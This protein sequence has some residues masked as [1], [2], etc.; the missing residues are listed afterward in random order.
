MTSV[1]LK[2]WNQ[3]NLPVCPVGGRRSLPASSSAWPHYAVRLPAASSQYS[4]A[5]DE[6]R[7]RKS[8]ISIA[9]NSICRCSRDEL[10]VRRVWHLPRA[11]PPSSVTAENVQTFINQSNSTVPSTRSDRDDFST[12]NSTFFKQLDQ[13]LGD[14]ASISS[15]RSEIDDIVPDRPDDPFPASN[16][17]DPIDDLDGII[18]TDDIPM[19]FHDALDNLPVNDAPLEIYNPNF[20]IPRAHM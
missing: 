15:L 12:F 20:R 1:G 3:P 7:T 10:R 2:R 5:V 8:S 13:Q 6:Q 16:R 19:L 11:T 18:D 17:R 9:T 14:T 4:S